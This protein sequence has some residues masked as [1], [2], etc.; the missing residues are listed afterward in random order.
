[1]TYEQSNFYRN[2]PRRFTRIKWKKYYVLRDR[3]V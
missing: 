2:L 3:K 1:M